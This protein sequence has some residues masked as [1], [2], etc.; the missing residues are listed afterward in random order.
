VGLR[1]QFP[2]YDA[3]TSDSLNNS[4]PFRKVFGGTSDLVNADLCCLCQHQGANP[5]GI[6]V[7]RDHFVVQ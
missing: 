6:Q 5:S 3:V 4:F 7:Q 2:C 1:P